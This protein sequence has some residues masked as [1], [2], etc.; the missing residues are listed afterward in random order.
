[1]V[2][3]VDKG[4]GSMRCAQFAE[5]VVDVLLDGAKRH[6]EFVSDL[7]VG[8]PRRHQVKHLQFA[9]AKR[10]DQALCG[11]QVGLSRWRRGWGM[12]VTRAG[13]LA[14]CGQD[15]ACVRLGMGVGKT[16]PQFGE[17][18][19]Q[20]FTLVEKYTEI[21]FGRGARQ[22]K[23]QAHGGF[24]SVANGEARPRLQQVHLDRE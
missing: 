18:P 24:F 5:N 21:S 20:G 9:C 10:L 14:Q 4:L 15:N 12:I 3:G 22:G 23:T 1:M 2:A 19:S 11:R 8:K 13:C 6:D 7:L 17:Q 16:G